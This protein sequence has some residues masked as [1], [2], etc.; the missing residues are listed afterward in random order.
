MPTDKRFKYVDDLT[1][2][3]IINLLSVGLSSYNFKHHVPSD[4]PTDGY[5]LPNDNLKSQFYIIEINKWTVNQKMLINS[6]KTKAMIFNFT[7]NYKFSTQLRNNNMNIDVVPEIKILG[8]IITQDIN[9]NKNTQHIIQ[10][11]NKRM[12]LIKK[13]MSF[14]ASTQEI[15][16]LWIIYCRSILEQSA[17]VWSSSLTEQNTKDLER[18]QKCFVKLLLKNKYTT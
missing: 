11:V 18:I 12:L 4:I 13:I 14:G 10:K 1:T 5:F 16:H 9:W 15:V 17:V 7:H 3:E 8:T 6:K 2:L